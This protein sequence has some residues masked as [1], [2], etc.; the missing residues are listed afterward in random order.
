[1]AD[2]GEEHVTACEE[3][4]SIIL[5]IISQLRNGTDLSRLSLPTF[6]LEP[7]SMTERLS[8]F[9]SHHDLL[10]G[11]PSQSETDR[12]IGT[13]RYFLSGFHVRPSVPIS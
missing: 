3:N 12:F 13:L 9:C 11:L 1:M 5:N 7:R 8:D 6:V 2:N 10:H 4:R